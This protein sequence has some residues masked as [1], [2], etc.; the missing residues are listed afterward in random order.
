[1]ER[2]TRDKTIRFRCTEIEYQKIE[3]YAVSRGQNFSQVLREYIRRLPNPA[4]K[5]S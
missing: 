1:M 2:P 3:A 5:L 4:K